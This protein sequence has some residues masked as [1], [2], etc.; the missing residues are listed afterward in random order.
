MSWTEE[1]EEVMRKLWVVDRLSTSA[2]AKKLNEMFGTDMT[3]NSII[4]KV[5]R[6]GL[7]YKGGARDNVAPRATKADRTPR[8]AKPKQPKQPRPRE[9]AALD[10]LFTRPAPRQATKVIAPLA[11]PQMPETSWFGAEAVNSLF[12]A[13]PEGRACKWPVGDPQ[14][15]AFRFCNTAFRGEGSYCPYHNQ[16]A[17]QA[18]SRQRVADRQTE[19]FLENESLPE[20][21]LAVG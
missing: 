1:R 13:S 18:G 6:L 4:G 12:E 19:R 9:T 21:L 2:I 14:D 20:P 17:Y 10:A 5:N 16:L 3:K 8:E 11:P 7:A 15:A